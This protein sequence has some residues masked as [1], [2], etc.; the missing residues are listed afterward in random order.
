MFTVY[1]CKHILKLQYF[2]KDFLSILLPDSC[3]ACD[4]ILVT[5]EEVICTQCMYHL[6][7][8]GFHHYPDNETARQLWGKLDFRIAV[9]MFHLSK[10]S[11]VE[12]LVHRLKYENK[13]QI[14]LF[15][16]K[17]YGKILKEELT[18]NEV[19]GIVPV[20]I[21]KK[22]LRQRGYNQ[23]LQFAKGMS[24]VTGLP[25]YDGFLRR[26]I[27]SASQVQKIRVER[28]DNVKNVFAMR[29]NSG[30]LNNKHILLVDDILTTGAT[31]CE[32]GKILL[33]SGSQISVATI[34]R[35]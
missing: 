31:I 6:P 27:Y 2:F 17:M 24:L 9:S 10:H 23:S 18:K 29:D 21:H 8:T 16:G 5:H 14:G 33:K 11:R 15:L 25:V 22:K 28:Y 7:L 12:R 32:A 26:R 1:Q 34:A 3:L 20:P 13:P 35:A 19:E 4:R 30:V